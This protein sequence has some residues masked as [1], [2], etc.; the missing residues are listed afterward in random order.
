[1]NRVASTKV[2]HWH[3]IGRLRRSGD[4]PRRGVSVQCLCSTCKACALRVRRVLREEVTGSN[5]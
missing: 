4:I 1:M 3:K 5:L 2:A